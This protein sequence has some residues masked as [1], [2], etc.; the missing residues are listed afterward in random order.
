MELVTPSSRVIG[1]PIAANA[2]VGHRPYVIDLIELDDNAVRSIRPHT[3]RTATGIGVRTVVMDKIVGQ[4][5]T[6][7][8]GCE[9]AIAGSAARRSRMPTD[10]IHLVA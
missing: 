3:R 7:N 9:Y 2:L 1:R 8:A 6:S 10:V 4:F 5:A